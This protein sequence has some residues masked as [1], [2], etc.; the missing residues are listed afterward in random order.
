MPK[1]VRS[2]QKHFGLWPTK[3]SCEQSRLLRVRPTVCYPCNQ[4]ISYFCIK[5]CIIIFEVIVN[6]EFLWKYTVVWHETATKIKVSFWRYTW[7]SFRIFSMFGFVAN[8]SNDNFTICI[9]RYV[10]L[11]SVCKLRLVHHRLYTFLKHSICLKRK[12]LYVASSW[13][14]RSIFNTKTHNAHSLL[15]FKCRQ[16]LRCEEP[17]P[18]SSQSEQGAAQRWWPIVL[19]HWIRYLRCKDKVRRDVQALWRDKAT[20]HSAVRAKQ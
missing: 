5:H 4:C 18:G 11:C 17:V 16:A 8:Y 10:Y 20:R 7:R 6:L 15:T 1:F 2:F 3:N 9:K 12:L 19:A 14:E 13:C